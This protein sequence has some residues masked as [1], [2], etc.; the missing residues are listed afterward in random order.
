MADAAVIVGPEGGRFAVRSRERID[1]RE[2]IPDGKNDDLN[3]IAFRA[4]KDARR[5]IAI[6]FAKCR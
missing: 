2:R 4:R 1:G 3:F 5:S 6:V